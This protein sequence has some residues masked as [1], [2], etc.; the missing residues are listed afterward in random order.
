M[1]CAFMPFI[2]YLSPKGTLYTKL[3]IL[4]GEFRMLI[5]LLALMLL[6]IP[7][8]SAATA[9]TGTTSW[10]LTSSALVLLMTLPGLAFFYGG[11]A[12]ATSVLSVFS[13]CLAVAVVAS[14]LWM[15]CGYSLSFGEGGKYIGDFSNALFANG[16]G[17]SDGLPD[18]AFF[19]FQMTFAIITPALVI[20][21]WVERVRFSAVL[22]FTVLFLLFIYF[23]VAH[24]VWGGGWLAEMG[25]IDFA[26]GLVVHTTAGVSALVIAHCIRPRSGFPSQVQPPHNP[27]LAFGG[28]AMLWV[29]W[30]GFNG[31]SALV[32]DES[33]AMAITATH[34]S[35]ATATGVWMLMDWVR[36]GKPTLVGMA[37][38]AI[39][40][41]ATITPA[42]GVS[43]PLG[44]V[45]IGALASFVCYNAVVLIK[46]RF[47]I[48][49]S[50]DVFAVHGVGGML[51]TLM[52]AVVALPVLQGAGV[53]DWVAQLQVQATGIVAVAV[54][55][56]FVSLVMVWLIR[57]LLGSWTVAE[58]EE[59]EGLDITSHGERGYDLK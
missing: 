53:D 34:L 27:G 22:L 40:G 21:A 39:A 1:V 10:I 41:L 18:A 45:I 43:G 36:Y 32:A 20:G 23:P 52:A 51:G 2:V 55:S 25:A 5:P 59:I 28:A 8:A 29:G 11:L 42:A 38:G 57:A 44:G 48:D 6:F 50:L 17:V 16:R 58:T 49:D 14:V 35:A 56:L 46:S 54:W 24:W 19:L 4:Q 47:R 9:D 33:A 15:V 3:N 7:S 31:G 26:G 13:Q 30:F 37:T 12:R